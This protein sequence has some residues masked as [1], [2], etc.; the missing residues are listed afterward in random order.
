MTPAS[1]WRE[2]H[3]QAIEAGRSTYIDPRTGFQVFTELG[4]RARGHCCGSGCRHCPYQ[5]ES[6]ELDSRVAGAQQPSWLTGAGPSDDPADVL[7]WSGG[8]DSFLCYRVLTREAVRPV[9]LLT[10]FDAASRIVAHQEI[11][12]RQVVRQAEHLG[13]PLLGVPLHPGHPYVD[14]IR[15]A[16][17]LVPGIARFV[18][19]DLHLRHIREWRDKAFR[20]LAA[21]RGAT[22]HFPLWGVSPETL[23]A[24]LEA[25]G[26]VCEVSAV[27]EPAED[28]IEVGERFDRA[29]MT[30]LPDEIDPFGENGEFHTLA[31]VWERQQ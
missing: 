26:A 17:A 31:K 14:R 3:R 30:R 24:D 4:L 11:G 18:F 22:L 7:F 12:V 27:T 29:M 13:L 23:I 15:E 10:T 9:V 20:D 25:S 28:V 8:K 2:A 5:H 6:M 1:D 21:E 19:G 16:V